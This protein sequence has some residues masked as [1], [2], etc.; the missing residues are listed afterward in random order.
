[1]TPFFCPR[2]CGWV[3]V[4]AVV[5]STGCATQRVLLDDPQNETRLFVT[6]SADQ[7]TLAWE[8]RPDYAYTVYYNHTRS[9]GSPWQPVPGLEWIR[10]TGRT[11]TYT[12]RVPARQDRF[13]RLKAAPAVSISP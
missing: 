5:L 6:R 2:L 13:Y 3:V 9:A 10:G 4:A 12:D 1:M 8:T 7:V 11:V